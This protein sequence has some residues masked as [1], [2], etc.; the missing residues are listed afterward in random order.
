MKKFVKV[1]TAT[2]LVFGIWGSTA[3]MASENVT[4]T[5]PIKAASVQV[6]DKSYLNNAVQI[7]AKKYFAN[8]NESVEWMIGT[9]FFVEGGYIVGA[10]HSV[11][12]AEGDDVAPG[13]RVEYFIKESTVNSE[14][15]IVT[16]LATD[17]NLDLALFKHD[18]E[19]HTY[20]DIADTVSVGQEMF[21]IGNS[22]NRP[23]IFTDFIEAKGNV[24]ML[25]EHTRIGHGEKILSATYRM[26]ATATSLPGD[27]G[28]PAL[29]KY[30]E[31]IGVVV[32]ST[33]DNHNAIMVKLQDLKDF[34][35]KHKD[36]TKVYVKSN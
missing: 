29:N 4:V 13:G 33:Y 14:K 21:L 25:N 35:A 18:L 32:A 30:N 12:S 22:V 17:S 15:R 26:H 1:I 20:F 36:E 24:I 19:G 9:G 23:G 7:W 28:G 11:G 10:Q 27:S 5:E 8:S 34:L 2:A 16:L 3:A 6:V 31:V